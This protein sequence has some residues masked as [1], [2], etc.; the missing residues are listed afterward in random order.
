VD[1]AGNTVTVPTQIDRIVVADIYPL[2]SVLSIFFDSAEKIVGM[3]PTSL[4]AA[5]NSLLSELYPEILDVETDFIDGTSINIEEIIAL[6]PDVV[7]YGA[8]STAIYEEL[9][10]AGI[11]A[12]GISA[13]KWDYDAIETL[14]NWIDLLGQIFPENDKTE[15]CTE[16]SNEIYDMVQERV[17][18]LSDEERA[19]VFF[20]FQYSDASI[21]TSGKH[22]FGQWWADAIGAINVG[23]ELETDNSTVVS[24][25]QIYDWNPSV[26]FMTN[27]NTS[28]PE[29]L[30]NNTVGTYDWSGIAA[31]E[32]QQ[33][34][35]MP[36]GMYRSYTPGIDTPITLM[37]LAKTVYP[38]LFEDIDITEEVKSYYS[39]VFGVTL[40]DEQA[41]MIFTPVS[42]AGAF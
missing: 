30:Y 28:Q 13:S 9:Q 42:E 22:F 15:I 33:V 40:T 10:N 8:G 2:P 27:F 31:V 20:L 26:I 21:S 6:E 34:Y 3:A 39:E 4:S 29:D 7:F 16:Y 18:T 24:M 12:V 36:L 1:H 5:Q 37:W 41:E 17:S 25:E 11:P 38:D 32:N 14:N 35:K 23:E 19:E